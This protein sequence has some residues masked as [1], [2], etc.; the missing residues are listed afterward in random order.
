M[1]EN[2]DKYIAKPNCKDRKLYRIRA[3]NFDVG[4]YNEKTC[5]FFGMRTKFG[6]TYIDDEYH[7]EHN[8]IHGTAKPIEELPEELPAEIENGYIKG[9]KCQVCQ[10]FC[11]YV[12]WPEG[13]EREITLKN[14][15]KMTVPGKWKHLEETDCKEVS[16]VALYNHELD[17][18]LREMT[19]KYHEKS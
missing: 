17:K 15:S 9:S 16:P 11:E 12:L 10:K 14:G 6:S 8:Q 1:W 5:S 18:W 4:V 2:I 3:R 19:A 7:W 13:R